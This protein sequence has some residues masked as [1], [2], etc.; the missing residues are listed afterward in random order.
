MITDKQE[1]NIIKADISKITY[2]FA[3]GEMRMEQFGYEVK[4]QERLSGYLAECT[5]LL[6]KDGHF[7]LEAPCKIA[8]YG[9]GVRR[10]LKGGTGS[11]EVNSRHVTTIEEALEN[12]GFEI[13]SKEW[14]TAYDTLYKEKRKEFASQCMEEAVKNNENPMLALMGMSMP[15]PEYELSLS[16]QAEAAVYVLGRISG[17]GNDRQEIKGDLLLTD[18]EIRDILWL[19]EK[20][21]KFMLILNVGGPVDLS[22]LENVKNI[23]V[24][25]QLGA[26]VGTACAEILLGR[27]NPS[28][29]LTTT[30][31]SMKDYC[32]ELE[33]G[34][35]DDTFYREGI[36]VGYRYFDTVGK[37]AL[38]P[39]GFWLSYTEFEVEADSFKVQG[40]EAIVNGTVKNMGR[41]A[42]KEVV[43]VYATLPEDKL[44][45]PYQVLA[46]FCKTRELKPGECENIAITI[47]L[48]DLASYCK[49]NK[50]YIL[51]KGDYIFRLGNSS[52]HTS[53]AGVVRLTEEVTTKYV[54]SLLPEA[55]VAPVIYNRENITVPEKIA[56][57]EMKASAFAAETVTY[58]HTD[59]ID[60]RVKSF[61]DQELVL[62][63]MGAFESSEAG[64]VIGNSGTKVAGA[65]G[66]TAQLKADRNVP[67]LVMADGPAGLRLS[68]E[69]YEDGE[70]IHILGS[71]SIPES[72][73][74]LLPAEMVEGL[75]NAKTP[76][77]DIQ[78]QYQYAT[79][80][81]IGT[82]IA[83]SWN[84]DFAALCG[85]I[86]GDEMERFGVQLWL[87]PALNIH[88]SIR[89]GRNFEYYS[90]DPLLSG[91][92]AAAVTNGVQKHEGC[93]VVIKHFAA[94]NQETNRMNNN[95]HIEERT[96]REIYLKGFGI[97]VRKSAPCAVMSSYNLVNGVHTSE[98][99]TLINGYLRNE[100]KFDGIVMT[101]WLLDMAMPKGKKWRH[102]KAHLIAN[103]GGDMIMPGEQKD[104]DELLNS[105]KEG[106]TNRKQLEI[107]V[108]RTLKLIKKL[109]IK[110]NF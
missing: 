99:E 60:E 72:I 23:L 24:L 4:N 49:E 21:E 58:T 8:A 9:S 59:W 85:D 105:L 52:V 39:F 63:S 50:G 12:Y 33:F 93:G 42:G 64:Y 79:A 16:D 89:C 57:C 40:T 96:M 47:N 104:Y 71:G 109:A 61:S 36:Y 108:S 20:Y 106:K 90:E 1:S 19:N 54:E 101:D 100:Q 27:Q 18:T 55:Q 81:P 30:W 51:E 35:Q 5:V 13:I 56:V 53:C 92:F 45:Q 102:P 87:A 98:M 3:V 14:L 76:S 82:A 17:E 26:K 62:M 69:Y 70:G 110:E 25:S 29:K 32:P 91:E 77:E 84:L 95:S 74:E 66:Q 38:Y 44:N 6:K 103:A 78:V 28:G 7:P 2:E 83:Q 46:G 31:S 67:V 94:N 107:N 41:F 80:I 15:E 86:V 73:T 11:G 88:R 97:C 68:P 43:Q 34:A 65:A 10:T 48:K 75:L 37:K 22:P